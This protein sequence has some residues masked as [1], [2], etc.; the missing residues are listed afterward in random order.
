MRI[1][2]LLVVIVGVAVFLLYLQ[3]GPS[4][5]AAPTSGQ[6][7]PNL[8]ISGMSAE[9]GP[10][11]EYNSIATGNSSVPGA[12]RI[13]GSSGYIASSVSA[14]GAY[15]MYPYDPQM[16][17]N[18]V[19]EVF[20]LGSGHSASAALRVEMSAAVENSTQLGNYTNAS[21]GLRYTPFSTP[22]GIVQVY[23]L[24]SN[25]SHYIHTVNGSVY[26]SS[27]QYLSLFSCGDYVAII[28]STSNNPELYYRSGI[29]VARALIARLE[30]LGA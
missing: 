6:L 10:L 23:E 20:L 22:A 2:V 7:V 28:S 4:A 18:V 27:Y 12:Q 16:P 30:S 9:F 1:A 19:S 24:Y 8:N 17:T 26:V 29:D 5:L 21:T 15:Q 11:V 14:F 25:Q 3:H 13:Y